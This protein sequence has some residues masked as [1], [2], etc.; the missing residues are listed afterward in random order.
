MGESE[1]IRRELENHGA[2]AIRTPH[3][4]T[5]DEP[6]ETQW[7]TANQLTHQQV[8]GGGHIQKNTHTTHTHCS[9][10]FRYFLIQLRE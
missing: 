6:K 9:S 5:K 1:E 4:K 8:R 10:S 7:D 2:V 3:K